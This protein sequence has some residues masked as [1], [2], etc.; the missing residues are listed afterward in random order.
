MR[1][2]RKPRSQHLAQHS[3][4]QRDAEVGGPAPNDLR[5]R[6]PTGCVVLNFGPRLGRLLIVAPGPLRHRVSARDWSA[7]CA[8]SGCVV[9]ARHRQTW[10]PLVQHG[11][12][13]PKGLS[14]AVGG[15][16]TSLYME[17]RR[18]LSRLG[19]VAACMWHHVS[20]RAGSFGQHQQMILGRRLETKSLGAGR[21]MFCSPLCRL[22]ERRDR[23]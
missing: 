20:G 17:C 1:G 5:R 23:R 6:A 9:D 14:S 15:A 3:S 8:L 13:K 2:G 11:A 12:S 19:L 22:S 10:R 16:P 7:A 18:R 4:V 21:Q